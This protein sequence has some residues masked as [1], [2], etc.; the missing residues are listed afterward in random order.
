M[1]V[2]AMYTLSIYSLPKLQEDIAEKVSHMETKSLPNAG[3]G[4]L[5]QFSRA[6][7]LKE[8]GGAKLSALF[9]RDRLAGN[10]PQSINTHMSMTPKAP[11]TL[12]EAGR[13]LWKWAV[14]RYEID[15]S[16]P[17]LSELCEI[18]DRLASVRVQ[19]RSANPDGRLIN[20]EVKLLS[21]YSRIWKL[22]GFCDNEN[23]TTTGRA[24]Y[25]EGR[26]RNANCRR[27]V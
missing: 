6:R 2:S 27:T 12:G 17:L 26:P 1:S 7:S 3:P 4:A 14:S 10:D 9:S 16:T 20:S 24:G 13:K 22:L 21:Q 11:K 19:L 23:A 5:A 18:C 15:D 8:I 25:P